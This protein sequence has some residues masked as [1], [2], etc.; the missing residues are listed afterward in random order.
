MDSEEEK[1]SIAR[2][3]SRS[4]SLLTPSF[5]QSPGVDD[6]DRS[7]LRL[8]FDGRSMISQGI[9]DRQRRGALQKRIQIDRPKD[10]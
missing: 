2:V 8:Q 4:A 7:E 6:G 5:T 3:T 1:R 9:L 10:R